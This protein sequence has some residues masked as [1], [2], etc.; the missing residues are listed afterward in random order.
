MRKL[1]QLYPFLSSLVMIVV[2][3][4]WAF[5]TALLAYQHGIQLPH[6]T[7]PKDVVTTF[8]LIMTFDFVIISLFIYYKTLNKEKAFARLFC[9]MSDCVMSTMAVALLAFI[10]IN[11]V[12]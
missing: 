3:T 1:M 9:V 12:Y 11:Y 2:C 8:I 4:L 10:F 7:H 5:S 6:L